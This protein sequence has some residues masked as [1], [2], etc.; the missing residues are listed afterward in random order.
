LLLIKIFCAANISAHAVH[1]SEGE[2]KGVRER[3]KGKEQGK[4]DINYMAL[5]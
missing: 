1:F 3:E 2:K 5:P 4:R